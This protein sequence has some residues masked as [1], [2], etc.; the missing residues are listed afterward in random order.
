M[1]FGFITQPQPKRGY[2]LS[3]FMYEFACTFLK[4]KVLQKMRSVPFPFPRPFFKDN[5]FFHL[6]AHV[7]LMVTLYFVD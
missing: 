7:F 4:I 1:I 6:L 5:V 2:V 3:L